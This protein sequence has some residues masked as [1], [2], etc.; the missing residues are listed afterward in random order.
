M[1]AE[2]LQLIKADLKA[3]ILKELTGKDLRST[4]ENKSKPLANVWTKYREPL[5]QKFGTVTYHQAWECIRKLAVLKTGHRY[6]RDLLP[7]EEM[8]AAEFAESVLNQLGVE[9]NE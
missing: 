6:I 4:Q 2:E 8:E 1:N 9:V 7:S 3:E 5:F